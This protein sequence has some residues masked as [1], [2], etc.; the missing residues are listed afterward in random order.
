MT[1][2][3]CVAGDARVNTAGE[4]G[5]RC[6]KRHTY[7]GW[8]DHHGWVYI[9]MCGG[10]AAK[11]WVACSDTVHAYVLQGFQDRAAAGARSVERPR[12]DGQA[13][14]RRRWNTAVGGSRMGEVWQGGK[15]YVFVW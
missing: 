11:G 6:D 14:A 3:S 8:M 7:I 13:K 4:M 15:H 9:H 1:Y 12:V 10:E 5:V 2:G